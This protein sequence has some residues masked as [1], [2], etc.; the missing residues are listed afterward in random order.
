ML[1]T[2]LS[3]LFQPFSALLFGARPPNA[4]GFAAPP[5]AMAPRPR[6]DLRAMVARPVIG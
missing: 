5:V 6:G 3:R 2:P 4:S 1:M